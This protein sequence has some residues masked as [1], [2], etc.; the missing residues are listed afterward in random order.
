MGHAHAEVEKCNKAFV[1]GSFMGFVLSAI[2][3]L[4]PCCAMCCATSPA[5][6]MAQQRVVRTHMHALYCLLP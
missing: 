6:M 5:T 4:V 3:L 1:V 2:L